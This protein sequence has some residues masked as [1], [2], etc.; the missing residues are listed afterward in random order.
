MFQPVICDCSVE[1]YRHVIKTQAEF[2]RH[3]AVKE[4]DVINRSIESEPSSL[5]QP[6]FQRRLTTQHSTL[7]RRMKMSI[8]KKL[9][10]PDEIPVLNRKYT[11]LND[12]HSL[13][14]ELDIPV[15]GKSFIKPIN[16]QPDILHTLPGI[17]AQ[18]PEISLNN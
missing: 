10:I 18:K 15:V 2:Q 8:D 16:E 9:E 14:N 4:L 17:L 6:K 5:T 12:Q 7:P 1:Q 11:P 3:K 13:P